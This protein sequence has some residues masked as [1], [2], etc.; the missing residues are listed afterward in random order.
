MTYCRYMT[1]ITSV[2]SE[3]FLLIARISNLVCTHERATLRLHITRYLPDYI[4]RIPTIE[5]SRTLK[6]CLTHPFKYFIIHF[7]P[8]L[9]THEIFSLRLCLICLVPKPTYSDYASFYMYTL[10]IYILERHTFVH[11]DAMIHQAKSISSPFER[12]SPPV[13]AVT[14]SAYKSDGAGRAS[15]R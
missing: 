7:I 15:E 5:H 6:R 2:Q 13:C 14:T 10:D 4:I 12:T 9:H 1:K 3:I 11:W 8:Q